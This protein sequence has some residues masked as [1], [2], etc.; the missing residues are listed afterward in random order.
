MNKS[1]EFR[2]SKLWMALGL[3]LVWRLALLIFTAQPMP[4]ND[5]F[6]FDGGVV[7]WLWHGKYVNPCLINAYPISGGRV[8]SLYPPFYQIPLLLWMSV[9]GTGALSAM[10][11]H[12]FMFTADALLAVMLVRNLFPRA[13][14][15]MLAVLF[16]FAVTWN[17]RPED[18]AHVLGLGSLFLLARQL[19]LKSRDWQAELGIALLLFATLYTSLIVGALY[20]GAGLLTRAVAWKL[21]RQKVSV[22]AFAAAAACF[23]GAT[24]FIM[25]AHPLWWQ[26]F[27]ENA[28]RGTDVGNGILH[29]LHRPSLDSLLKVGRNAPVFF[30]FLACLPVLI[31]NRNNL[32]PAGDSG[33]AWVSLTLGIG[34]LG[35]VFIGAI[36][37]LLPS[38]YVT[39]LLFLQVVLAAGLL[40]LAD[41]L[42]PD[43]RHHLSVV[44]SL[45]L[46]LV[47]V[48]A[49]GMTTWGA[50]CAYD[51]GYGR[52]CKI[53]R[54]E[55]QD[56]VKTDEPVILSSAFLYEAVRL[57]VKTPLHADWF[58]D[59]PFTRGWGAQDFAAL[60]RLRPAKIILSQFDYYRDYPAL[61]EEVRRHPDLVAVE[62]RDTARIRTPDSNASSQMVVQHISWAPII[63]DLKWK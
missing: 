33:V 54:D 25:E 32:L 13:R 36:F 35:I 1:S 12:F 53:L 7:N 8:F 23:A 26:G 24:L 30:I 46:L 5:A 49:I 28:H 41:R 43:A 60:Q 44:L 11:M 52:S 22:I 38:N 55:L 20:F 61:V 6:D 14:S 47:S 18:F 39:Y 62:I 63:I 48:R 31:K 37:V 34:L 58:A 19:Q 59:R 27:Q 10:W 2:N 42:M 57:D 45:C 50:A 29:A 21:A 40:A 3:V 4:A 16:L 9:F 56:Y 51:V 17:D 15:Y